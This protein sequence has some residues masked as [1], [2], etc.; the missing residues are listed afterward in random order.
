MFRSYSFS[1]QLSHR[2]NSSL[3]IEVLGFLLEEG[4]LS[5]LLHAAILN[6]RPPPKVSLVIMFQAELEALGV[7]RFKSRFPFSPTL[8]F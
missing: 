6:L 7:L 3:Y 8:K 5:V 1:P 4:E 2:H